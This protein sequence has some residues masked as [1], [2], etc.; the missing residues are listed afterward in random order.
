MKLYDYFR[1]ENG[2]RYE[3]VKQLAEQVTMILQTEYNADHVR[4]F[5]IIPHR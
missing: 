2:R 3:Q 1:Y 4:F 5:G